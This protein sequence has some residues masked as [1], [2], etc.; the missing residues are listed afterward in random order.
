MGKDLLEKVEK[1]NFRQDINFLRALAVLS[2]IVYHI[3]PEL[4]PGGWLGVDMFFF[5]SG[6]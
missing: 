4:L 6:I 1:L 3:K 2:V 5:I